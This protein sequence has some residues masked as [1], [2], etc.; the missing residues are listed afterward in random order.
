VSDPAKEFYSPYTY[1]GNNPITALDP[2]GLWTVQ[3]GLAASGGYAVGGGTAGAGIVFGWSR[4][5]GF[6]MGEYGTTGG[7]VFLGAGGS[8]QLDLTWSGNNNIMDLE[9]YSNAIGFSTPAFGLEGSVPLDLTGEVMPSA[10]VS[11]GPT[12]S[13]MYGV[14]LHDYLVYTDIKMGDESIPTYSNE[15]QSGT[16]PSDATS[17]R[18]IVKDEKIK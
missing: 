17:T 2:N 5:N 14:E 1:V 8:L 10:T 13:L 4:E 3:I 11:V 7:G 9:G 15:A 18:M 6:Q 16:A 12:G